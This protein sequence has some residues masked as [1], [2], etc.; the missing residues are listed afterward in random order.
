MSGSRLRGINAGNT[1]LIV[2]TALAAGS[3]LGTTIVPMP[4]TLRILLGIP[5][6]LV[7][8][9]YSLVAAVFGPAMPPA[10]ERTLLALSASIA[11]AITVAV[12]LDG[13]G[14]RIEAASFALVFSCVTILGAGVACARRA[15]IQVTARSVVSG[16]R[17]RHAR[18]IKAWA[19]GIGG[20]ALLAWAA[21]IPP[22]SGGR[23]AGTTA[24]WAKPSG[25]SSVRMGVINEESRRL[26][27]RL[28]VRTSRGVVHQHS[29][30]L[31]PASEWRGR[32]T[33]PLRARQADDAEV[34]VVWRDGGRTMRRRVDVGA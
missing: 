21:G 22:G 30:V 2:A 33:L 8:P 5:F 12:V 3:L 31:E 27:Y 20:F 25:W 1:D 16:W 18:L 24:L 28:E 6:V 17:G 32:V 34:T 29:F 23:V 11:L 4:E 9:G 14:I 10:L 7:A 13:V 19:W 26:A 15:A